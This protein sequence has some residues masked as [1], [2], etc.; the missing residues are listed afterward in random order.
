MKHPLDFHVVAKCSTTKARVGSLKLPHATVSTPVFM[1]VGTQGTLKGL[2][3]EQI[4]E[5]NCNLILANTYHLGMRPGTE[6][7][8]KAQGL[9]NFM[10]WKN[11]L[12][13]DSGGFQMV[14]L[15]KFSELTEE[16][17]KFVSPYDKR[18]ILLTPEKSMEIQNAI[19]ADIMMQLDDVVSSLIDDRARVELAME[20][21]VRWLDR[22]LEAHRN[23]DKQNLYPI[24]QGGLHPDLRKVCAEKLLERYVAG[25]AI[26]GLSG[27]ESK[28]DFWRM[29]D[30]ST[31]YLPDEKPRYLMGVG[32]AVDLVVCAALGCD[33][34][35]CVYPTRTARFG[36]ALVE[37]GHVLPLHR[38][39]YAEDFRP[40]EENCPC[41]TCTNYTRA[42]LHHTVRR[43]T[44]ACHLV[45]V[46]NVNFQMRLM[47]SIREAIIE[48][49]F[50]QF[51]RKFMKKA[52]PNGI[53]PAWI[54]AALAKVNVN[55]SAGST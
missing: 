31:D 16:G 3:P 50:P 2:L 20:R 47:S 24:V 30:L 44:V 21:S 11:A 37:G 22:S 26:G 25:Y 15:L 43:E 35:D 52:Y 27:G 32:F 5:Q 55:L 45:S 1:P 14:S 49:R 29:V 34:F 54:V 18:E 12:L 7:L 9:H 40:I 51:I 28:E 48:D 33:Q 6:V 4:E 39:V 38:S 10:R 41:N 23:K 46:H 13:T 19:G 36:S 8:N 17:V 53:Y 42:F